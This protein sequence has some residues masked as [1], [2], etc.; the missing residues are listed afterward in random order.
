MLKELR[1]RHL[2]SLKINNKIMSMYK[3]Y[4]HDFLF[5]ETEWLK[6][7]SS[8]DFFYSVNVYYNFSPEDPG[9]G[10]DDLDY[11]NLSVANP[12][13]LHKYLDRCIKQN[14]FGESF[15]FPNVYITPNG[16]KETIMSSIRTE[17]ENLYAAS[18]KEAVLKVF[19]KFGPGQN[20]LFTP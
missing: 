14:V 18:M 1:H 16:N 10:W 6:K 4:I 3:F 15:L 2:A 5:E 19:G 12:G 9:N 8:D 17:L 11:F 13:G 7:D 20:G